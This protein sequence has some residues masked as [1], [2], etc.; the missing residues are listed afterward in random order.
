M[1]LL[2]FNPPNVPVIVRDVEVT[3]VLS[4]VGLGGITFTVTVTSAD[5]LPWLSIALYFTRYTPGRFG[6]TSFV[7]VASFTDTISA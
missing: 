4:N 6:L 3:G 7:V 2:A 1:L 5:S